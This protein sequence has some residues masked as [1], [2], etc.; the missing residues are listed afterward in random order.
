MAAKLEESAIFKLWPQ[1]VGRQILFQTHPDSLRNGVL[2]V[3]TTSS[4]WVQ[5]LHFIKAEIRRK[6]NELAGKNAVQE[7]RFSTGHEIKKHKATDETTSS[8]IR[9]LALNERDKKMIEECTASLADRELA[10]ICQRVME[11]EIN[12]RRQVR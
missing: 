9:K 12:R 8:T 3:K 7:I 5:Q 6:L 1:A 2:F 4:V 11:K 10:A